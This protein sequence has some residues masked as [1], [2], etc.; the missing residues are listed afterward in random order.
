[1]EQAA[2]CIIQMSRILDILE[3][4]WSRLEVLQDR[5]QHSARGQDRQIRSTMPRAAR[6]HL[7]MLSTGRGLGINLYSSRRGHPLR[8]RLE[9][10]RW[11]C[12]PW[13][14]PSGSDRRSRCVFRLVVENT[15]DE[16]IVEKAEIKL[17]WTG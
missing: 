12:R 10:P 14:E 13:T 16:K 2:G 5:R 6:S 7:F 15:V 11:T 9:L 3:D 1:M 17:S 4:S 8:L